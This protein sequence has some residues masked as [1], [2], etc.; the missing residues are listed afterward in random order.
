MNATSR[1]LVSDVQFEK[2]KKCSEK[3]PVLVCMTHADKL[4]AEFMEEEEDPNNY[5]PAQGKKQIAKQ[6][7]V[8]LNRSALNIKYMRSKPISTLQ[9]VVIN[10]THC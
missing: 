5:R 2:K 1:S 8:S 6:F 4:L 9:A 7:N 10:W 3:V